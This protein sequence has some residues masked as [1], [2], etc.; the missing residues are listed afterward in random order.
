MAKKLPE[1]RLS[2]ALGAQTALFQSLIVQLIE[3]RVLTVEQAERG[4]DAAFKRTK[5]R[6][7]ASGASRYVS[8]LHDRLPWACL[9][10]R[11]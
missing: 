10:G 4:F 8:H 2:E 1:F 5:E 6:A 7:G 11:K 3:A 9:V